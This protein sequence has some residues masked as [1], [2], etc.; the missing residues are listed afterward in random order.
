MRTIGAAMI[1]I[2]RTHQTC[3][4]IA[5]GAHRAAAMVATNRFGL[6]PGDPRS[7]DFID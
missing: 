5:I 3:L 2:T 4:D 7:L 1:N 6:G